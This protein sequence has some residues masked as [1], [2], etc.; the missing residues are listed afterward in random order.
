MQKATSG[1]N[2]LFVGAQGRGKSN[3]IKNFLKNFQHRDNYIFDPNEEYRFKN[4]ARNIFEREEFLEKVPHHKKA[5]V[6]VVFDE[7]SAFF[8]KSGSL[9]RNQAVHI[10]RRFHTQNINIYGYHDLTQF[11][12]D[13]MIYVDFI[14]LFRTSGSPIKVREKFGPYD[15]LIKA[16]EDVQ[17][18]TEDTFFDRM[19]KTYPDDRS[20]QWYHYNQVIQING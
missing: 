16:Y 8:S 11:N 15:K 1:I 17:R 19:N 2:I 14:V 7:A 13:N 9:P 3:G 20:R 12:V 6:N 18:R 10:C 4:K 5:A